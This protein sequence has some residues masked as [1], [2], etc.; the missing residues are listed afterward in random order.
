MFSLIS[1]N[2]PKVSSLLC[3]AV[4]LLLSYFSLLSKLYVCRQSHMCD[5]LD[6]NYVSNDSI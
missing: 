6:R 4:A 5:E 2:C 1:F 3:K